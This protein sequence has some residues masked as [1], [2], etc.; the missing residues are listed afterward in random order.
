MSG[1]NFS[2][3]TEVLAESCG[4]RN[5]GML[6][7]AKS[8]FTGWRFNTLLATSHIALSDVPKKLT[9]KL[10][11][12]KLDLLSEFCSN[13]TK[14]PNLK[15]AGLN[16]HAGEGG[17]IGDEEQA[18]IDPILDRLRESI[19]GLSC[20][21]PGD[22]VFYRQL[23]GDFDVIVAAYHDQALAAIKTLE[24]NNAVNLTLGLPYIRTS[25]D[26]GTAFDLAG[27][28]KANTDSFAS[29]IKVAREL[30]K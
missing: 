5:V 4:A 22:T 27:K 21:L 14:F 28:N 12:S 17:L 6:F 24:F 20:C 13:Y 29:A 18:V 3:Q 23:Q 1:H 19:P 15:V 2:G 16:P 7:T 9:Y 10:I 26:H 25:P 30:T 11:H 8:P